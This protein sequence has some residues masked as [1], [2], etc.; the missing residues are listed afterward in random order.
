MESRR[1]FNADETACNLGNSGLNSIFLDRQKSDGD[2]M[3]IEIQRR[4]K[5][6]LLA[7]SFLGG[8]YCL[9]NAFGAELFCG[10]RGCEI[11]AG[12]GLFGLSFY[13]YGF[14]GFVGIFLLAL[15][16]PR[17][18]ARQLLS[19]AVG[20]ALF[21]DTLFL[22]YQSLLWPCSSCHV[23]ALLI[24]LTAFFAVIGLEIPG[25]KFLLGIGLLWSVFFIF[26][27][28]AVV[29][30]VAFPPWPIYGS[31]E[32]QVKVYF[33]PTCPACEEAIRKIL[34][35]PE[36]AIE[37]AFYP[38]A[39]N[40]TD[41]ARLARLLRQA[42]EMRDAE[43]ILGLFE[44]EPDQPATLGVRE[45][46]LLF[47]NKMALARSGATRVPLIVSPSIVEIYSLDDGLSLPIES[48]WGSPVGTTPDAGCSAITDDEDCE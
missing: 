3:K 20:L 1:L 33:S 47:C 27:G 6:F 40:D 41:E 15:W 5:L 34:N 28:L 37:T 30:E 35:D 24:G 38:V 32:A 21:L 23:V 11:Y 22:I 9:L 44:K 45:K 18:P 31:T 29:K 17:R 42:G 14:V 8:L 16:F 26:V 10:T 46:F 36:V 43:A 12:Y 4:S 48:L 19:F 25:R 39:K 13:L 7:S 2:V